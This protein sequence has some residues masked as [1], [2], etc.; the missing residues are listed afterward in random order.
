MEYHLVKKKQKRSKCVS[1]E[2]KRIIYGAE[3]S[4]IF[5]LSRRL[6]GRKNCAHILLFIE[7]HFEFKVSPF[8]NIKGNTLRKKK[9]LKKL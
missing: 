1:A 6:M 4:A 8:A 9:S 3:K 5:F 2:W 7:F